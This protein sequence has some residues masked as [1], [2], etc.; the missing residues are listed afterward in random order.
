MTKHTPVKHRTWRLRTLVLGLFAGLAVF[1]IENLID[2]FLPKDSNNS[3]LWGNTVVAA[4]AGLIG[5]LFSTYL[6]LR[7]LR[8]GFLERGYKKGKFSLPVS[9]Q[10]WMMYGLGAV[11]LGGLIFLTA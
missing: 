7:A 11:L 2:P 6:A 4:V 8:R 9:A 1:L 5:L 3:Q 10:Y